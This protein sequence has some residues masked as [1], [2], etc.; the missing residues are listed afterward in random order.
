M[1][2]AAQL[3]RGEG[4]AGRGIP[5]G[6]EDQGHARRAGG[7]AERGQIGGVDSVAAV[8]HVGPAAHPQQVVAAAA[9][10]RVIAADAG[11]RVVA[12]A[13][14]QRVAGGGAGEPD[15]AGLPRV[16]HGD[17]AAPD[18]RGKVDV[19]AVGRHVE[20]TRD[21]V[22]PRH[23]PD[24]GQAEACAGAVADADPVLARVEIGDRVVAGIDDED[25]RAGAARQRVIARAADQEVVAFA[26]QKAV[27]TGPAQQPVVARA[28]VEQ[29]VPVLPGQMV[30]ARAAQQQ[31]GAVAAPERVVAAGPGHAVVAGPGQEDLVARLAPGIDTGGQPVCARR[32]GEGGMAF[33]AAAEDHVG[34]ACIRRPFVA[35]GRAGDQVGEAVGIHV[36]RGGKAGAKALAGAADHDEPVRGGQRGLVENPAPRVLAA[37]PGKPR[38]AVKHVGRA[39][40]GAARVVARHADGDVV[41]PVRVEIANPRDRGAPAV[42]AR[43]AQ[44][45][46]VAGGQR[47]QVDPP[48]AAAGPAE[49]ED[50]LAATVARQPLRQ[51]DQQVGQ[52][53]AIGIARRGDGQAARIGSRARPDRE[54][55]APVKRGKVDHPASA[56]VGAAEAVGAAVDHVGI[57]AV[58]AARGDDQVAQ[59]VA[60]DI[61]RARHAVAGRPRIVVAP[62]HEA[63]RRGQRGQVDPAAVGAGAEDDVARAARPLGGAK[64]EVGA[65]VAVHVAGGGHAPGAAAGV[66]A[67]REAL[68]GGQAAEVDHG[69]AVRTRRSETVLRPE[70][71]VGTRPHS[72]ARRAGNEEVGQPVAVDIPRRRN[73]DA[74]LVAGGCPLDHETPAGVEAVEVDHPAAAQPG[75][76]RAGAAEDHVGRA[77]I[78]AARVHARRAD[79]DIGEAVAIDVAGRRHAGA[80]RVAGTGATDHEA[81][82]FG[83]FD[84]PD[85]PRPDMEHPAGGDGEILVQV[86]DRK[87]EGTPVRHVIEADEPVAQVRGGEG[88][89]DRQRLA[90]AAQGA[91]LHGGQREGD[92]P[93]RVVGVDDIKV[94]RGQQVAAG[95]EHDRLPVADDRGRV[96]HRTHVEGDRRA[97]L[98]IVACRVLH[99]EPEGGIAGAEPVRFRRVDQP[100]LHQVLRRED[101]ARL[102]RHAVVA[103]RSG[104]GQA[105]DPHGDEGVAIRIG[106]A[107]VGHVDRREPVLVEHDGPVRR[108]RRIVQDH[109]VD[110]LAE[111]CGIVVVGDAEPERGGFGTLPFV[112]QLPDVAEADVERAGDGPALEPQDAG[113]GDGFDPHEARRLAIGG[114]VDIGER[115]IRRRESVAFARVE[116]QHPVGAGGQVV[117]RRHVDRKGFRQVRPGGFPLHQAFDVEIEEGI[118]FAVLVRGR[119]AEHQRARLDPGDRN[120]MRGRGQRLAI[121][122]QRAACGNG[123]EAHAQQRQV[124]AQPEIRDGEAVVD[125]LDRLQRL[126]PAA[127][128]PLFVPE[129]GNF[130]RRLRRQGIGFGGGAVLASRAAGGG[131]RRR[132]VL[133]GQLAG[134]RHRRLRC[135]PAGIVAQR[136]HRAN[137]RRQFD[138]GPGRRRGN[139]P[140]VR[141]RPVRL[142]VL[143]GRRG[144]A[145]LLGR[146]RPGQAQNRLDLHLAEGFGHQQVRADPVAVGEDDD[147]RRRGE[148]LVGEIAQ[149][150]DLARPADHDHVDADD[151]DRHDIATQQRNPEDAALVLQDD[152]GCPCHGCNAH[153]YSRNHRLAVGAG[154]EDRN[155]RTPP[156]DIWPRP[157]V[158]SR[159]KVRK[160]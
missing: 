26:A 152:L 104:R 112:G 18:Q 151:R 13:P 115:E 61:A 141:V 139:G 16:R 24:G 31:V 136:A 46:P 157:P 15:G 78:R 47:R 158:R 22:G 59:P 14:G 48:G 109:A 71:H 83:Q 127:D 64:H 50:G 156:P 68:G 113:A 137:L 101:L 7:T 94:A 128:Q 102:D 143:F 29:V 121:K 58:A 132:D 39:R 154:P 135:K 105:V 160:S 62:D 51:A 122:Q 125:V 30:V 93:R 23:R 27:R 53:V 70:D 120:V 4:G 88:A 40:I 131:Q 116:K 95:V 69:A 10:Q 108:G 124:L 84:D 107:E 28:A 67:D 19:V 79:E 42:V 91:V 145:V 114:R 99:A 60:V 57:A 75:S 45:Q 86:L 118:G 87:A 81:L 103:Q 6:V 38:P 56:A 106:K 5:A 142:R 20:R 77:R 150:D 148:R 36:A 43:P 110:G 49:E 21:E 41:E 17:R 33:A 111:P 97:R 3:A 126:R 66:A 129:F 147:G 54:A 100:A 98:G 2:D 153:S 35:R 63:I 144:G 159:V 155:T 133:E 92:L 82:A 130:P 37:K 65:A 80:R 85:P 34:L 90:R 140:G 146:H 119:G 73:G 74:G 11:Q 9:R 12:V 138:P 76:E 149:H 123:F 72:R 32:A 8:D 25:I 52:P 89:A 134:F 1:F 44:H 96:V 117:D 55:V